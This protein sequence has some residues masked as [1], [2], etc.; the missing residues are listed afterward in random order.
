MPE[1]YFVAGSLHREAL[2][3]TLSELINRDV[4]G[5][6]QAIDAGRRVLAEN[7]RA[8]YRLGPA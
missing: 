6:A 4:I 7:A 3:D 2:A 8:V 1:V 5:P